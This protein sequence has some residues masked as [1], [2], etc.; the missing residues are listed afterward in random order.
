MVPIMSQITPR[1]LNVFMVFFFV[2]FCFSF[3]SI[4][5]LL[6][7]L[8][9]LPGFANLQRNLY[10]LYAQNYFAPRSKPYVYLPKKADSGAPPVPPLPRHATPPHSFIWAGPPHQS[11]FKY[12]RNTA[13]NW[14]G[15]G[16]SVAETEGVFGDLVALGFWGGTSDLGLDACRHTPLTC[17]LKLIT[18]SFTKLLSVSTSIQKGEKIRPQFLS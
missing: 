16:G 15:G 9:S 14:A 8:S 10:N 2:M 4:P 6:P 7:L 12:S 18:L 3:F 1:S 17:K 11:P 13:A 5:F